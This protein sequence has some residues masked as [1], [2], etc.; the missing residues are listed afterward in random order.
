[1]SSVI[2]SFRYDHHP[3]ISLSKG[4]AE[5]REVMPLKPLSSLSLLRPVKTI[6]TRRVAIQNSMRV[7]PFLLTDQVFAF[8]LS[9]ETFHFLGGQAAGVEANIVDVAVKARATSN[10]PSSDSN[11]CIVWKSLMS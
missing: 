2:Y 7:K 4:S 8:G 10:T 1:M 5:I 3:K 9:V 11:K 6:L